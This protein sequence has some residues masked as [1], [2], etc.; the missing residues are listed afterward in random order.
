MFG[1]LAVLAQSKLFA[2]VVVAPLYKMATVHCILVSL[3]S[4]L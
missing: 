3:G 1:I 2:E 4:D